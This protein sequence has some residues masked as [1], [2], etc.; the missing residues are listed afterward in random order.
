MSLVYV[1]RCIIEI[2]GEYLCT[3]ASPLEEAFVNTPNPLASDVTFSE[4]PYK[5]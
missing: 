3:N 5:V 2:L 4:E 1:E